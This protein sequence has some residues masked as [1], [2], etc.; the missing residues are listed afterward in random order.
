MQ[1]LATAKILEVFRSIQGEGPYMGAAQVFVRF[2]ECNM[3]CTWCDTPASIGDTSRNYQEVPLPDLLA[4]VKDLSASCHSVSITGGEPLVQAEF[5]K[6]FLPQLKAAGMKIYLDTNGTLPDQL[7]QVIDDID[8]IAMDIKLPS[9]TQEKPFWAE[10]EEFLRTALRKEAFI[11][12]VISKATSDADVHKA[13]DM[14]RHSAPNIVFILQ[15]NYFDMKE[16]GGCVTRCVELQKYCSQF[17]KDVRIIP[18]VHKY[19]K[20][21]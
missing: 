5:L 11:K 8:I 20:L 14:V 9:S 21:R 6:E 2:F 17:L 15:P 19:M 3:H 1:Q 10:H 18:Q 4:Q 16:Q 7:R 12:V 13:V